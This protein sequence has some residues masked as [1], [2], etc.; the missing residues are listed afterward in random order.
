MAGPYAGLLP[1]AKARQTKNTDILPL[2]AG[3]VLGTTIGGDPSKINGV[4][5]PLAD[6]YVLIPTEITEIE[7]ARTAFNT[8]V[9]AIADAN[10]TRLA[11]ADVNLAFSNLLSSQAA[12]YNNIIITPKIDPPTGIYSEDGVHPNSR[13]YAFISNIFIEAINVKF[14]ST[15]PLTNISKYKATALPIP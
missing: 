14:G 13:G 15:I 4:T 1:Y 5:V 9:K 10:P 7:A 8:T 12:A 3:S 11:L 2:S 6:E